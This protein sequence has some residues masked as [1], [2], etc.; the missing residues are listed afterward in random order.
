[1]GHKWQAAQN[2]SVCVVVSWLHGK[3]GAALWLFVMWAWH[4]LATCSQGVLVFHP[5]A[6]LLCPIAKFKLVW[7]HC[8]LREG[9][10]HSADTTAYRGGI[11]HCDA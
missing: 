10:M 6:P 1:M 3:H 2:H 4:W 5:S 7:W 8:L 11:Q 9:P